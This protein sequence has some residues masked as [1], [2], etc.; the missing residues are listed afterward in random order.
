M[1][2]NKTEYDLNYATPTEKMSSDMNLL[3]DISSFAE[4]GEEERQKVEEQISNI[5]SSLFSAMD[6]NADPSKLKENAEILKSL[7]DK[8]FGKATEALSMLDNISKETSGQ[9]LD[10]FIQSASGIDNVGQKKGHLKETLSNL[11]NLGKG[12]EPQ[13]DNSVGMPAILAQKDEK[14][15]ENNSTKQMDVSALLA[16]KRQGRG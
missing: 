7:G 5:T 10:A 15:S 8:G 12:S 14:T 9:G 3:K 1:T 6:G 11:S 13:L 4:L 16:A 2:E